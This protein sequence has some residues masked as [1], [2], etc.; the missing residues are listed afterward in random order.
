MGGFKGLCFSGTVNLCGGSPTTIDYTA[1]CAH[2]DQAGTQ[3][4]NY[5]PIIDG[6]GELP[7]VGGRGE[8]NSSSQ[9]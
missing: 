2:E 4:P 3:D 7:V 9:N 1:E 5:T 8:I 6:A